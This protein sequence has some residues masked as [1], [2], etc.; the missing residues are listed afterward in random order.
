M[1]VLAIDCGTIT[2]FGMGDSF[3]STIDNMGDLLASP[4]YTRMETYGADNSP[5]VAVYRLSDKQVNLPGSF[6]LA[7]SLNCREI[8]Y[9]CGDSEDDKEAALLQ[10][11]P[12]VVA[13]NSLMDLAEEKEK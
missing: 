13:A 6:I 1:S 2:P 8:N 11:L 12:A 7:Y 3:E 5:W 4:K 10:I 9:V